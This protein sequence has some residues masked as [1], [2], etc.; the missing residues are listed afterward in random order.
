MLQR[1]PGARTAGW[2][3]RLAHPA[4]SPLAA[5]GG[6]LATGPGD[7]RERS[8]P[9]GGRHPTER[10]A[11]PKRRSPKAPQPKGPPRHP[12]KSPTPNRRGR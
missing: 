1:A 6:F 2:P 7:G 8:K 12:I 4:W 5:V 9:D 3:A 10:R 11:R